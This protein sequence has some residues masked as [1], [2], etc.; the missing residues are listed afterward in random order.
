MNKY[1]DT[2]TILKMQG[3]N[4]PQSQSKS[5]DSGYTFPRSG[6][7]SYLPT[8]MVPLAELIRIDKPVGIFYLYTLCACGTLLAASL[9]D[10]IVTPSRLVSA[11]VLLFISSA[12][13]R[14]AA[15]SWNDTADQEIDKNV[16]RTRLRPI[17]RGAVS[18]RTA[19]MCTGSLVFMALILQSQVP[20]LSGQPE[21]PL[22]AYYSIPFIIAAGFYPFSKRITHYPQVVL[23]FM[24]CWGVV[25]AYPSLGIDLFTSETRMAAAGSMSISVIAWTALDDT[26]YAF[27]DVNDDL[28]VGVKSMAVR[29]RNHAK[30]LFAGLAFVQV[31]ALLLTG[32]MV[33]AEMMY[34]IGVLT[35]SGLLGVIIRS[36][37]LGKAE[38]CAWWFH[39]GCHLVGIATVCSILSEYMVRVSS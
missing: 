36:V 10:P 35:V 30:V 38:S 3:K 17:A 11:N 26:I 16:L 14:G 29:H 37:D 8:R 2:Q 24:N 7:L 33:E 1:R 5:P 23:G 15:C 12:L 13:L 19:H 27:Q 6:M 21:S 20:R 31:L 32:S 34:Y 9:S 25:V 39:S 4:S 18:T 28:K 22:C